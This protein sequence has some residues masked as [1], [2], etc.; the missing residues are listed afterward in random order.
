MDSQ[1]SLE[2][3]NASTSRDEL[4]ALRRGQAALKSAIDAV[5]PAP[6]VH[7]LVADTQVASDVLDAA[8]GRDKVQHPLTKLRGV[9]ASS[10]AVLPCLGGAAAWRIPIIRLQEI[11]S[12]LY[13]PAGHTTLATDNTNRPYT[14]P[15]FAF[16]YYLD[17]SL[18][19]SQDAT[20]SLAALYSYDGSGNRVGRAEPVNGS[21]GRALTTYTYN[22]AGKMVSMTSVATNTLA[23]TLSYD[24]DGN[25]TQENDPNQGVTS[26]RYNHDSTLYSSTLTN[27]PYTLASWI[28]AYDSDYRITSQTFS[29]LGVGG[30]TP[31]QGTAS[32]SYDG[33]GRISNLTLPG[34]SAQSVSWDHD[35]NR[36]SYQG[37]A[38]TYNMDD[39]INTAG[40]TS[41]TYFPTGARRTDG[42]H[43]YCYDGYDRLF[44]A[45][46]VTD[47][48]C[49]SPTIS[50]AYEGLDRQ[51]AHSEG[52]GTTFIEYDGLSSTISEEYLSG[53]PSGAGTVYALAGSRRTAV[54]TYASGGVQASSINY[55]A[56]DGMGNI[57]TAVTTGGSMACTAW[58]DAWGVP[59][60]PLSSSNPCNTGS[61]LDTSFYTGSRR[62][63]ITGDYQFGVRTY[64][65]NT[66]SFLEPDTYLGS[67][68]GTRGS[69][70]SDPLTR[71]RYVYV[72]G[73]PLNLID[74]S[75][76]I[77]CRQGNP[78]PNCDIYIDGG[79]TSA[80]TTSS[81]GAAVPYVDNNSAGSSNNYRAIESHREGMVAPS[82][83]DDPRRVP[84]NTLPCDKLYRG[85]PE[86]SL[87]PGTGCMDAFVDPSGSC[88]F[89]N[90]PPTNGSP[91]GSSDGSIVTGYCVSAQAAAGGAVSVESCEAY[92][93]T[94]QGHL[95]T[96]GVGVGTPGAGVSGG[97]LVAH[98]K[99]RK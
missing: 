6:A 64:D 35:G 28:Y 29:G 38:Y 15:N 5:L 3:P 9:T 56:D 54:G 70:I 17:G 57:S 51:R 49:N 78:D 19:S 72:N 1:F 82:N 96:V 14:T 20:Y 33:A 63:Q 32:Y 99:D 80:P 73:D 30:V 46:T 88:D 34:Q 25:L 37:V 36:I 74:P 52:S 31:V 47:I 2:L 86:C 48:G 90:S 76:H 84:G 89:V 55:L 98:A 12:A 97:A 85:V 94:H 40:S 39:S 93:G 92:D 16:T 60:S 23:T 50:Y 24:L 65:P 66:G 45:T 8:A 69:V 71:N 75:G 18:R 44:R 91:Q 83:P 62:D 13:D 95:G 22:D 26:L 27:S 41:F 79:G 42:G 4:G 87:Q 68:P 61:T 11:Q 7:R 10:H 77:S 58:S 21:S 81:A 43:F 67:R 59:M 53:G